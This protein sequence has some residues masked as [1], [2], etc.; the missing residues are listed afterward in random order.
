MHKL[1]AL[2]TLAVLA[3]VSGCALKTS[4]KLEATNKVGDQT[5]RYWY[6]TLTL[7][8]TPNNSFI[9]YH[10]QHKDL[11]LGNKVDVLPETLK[12]LW[13]MDGNPLGDQTVNLARVLPGDQDDAD[14]FYEVNSPASFSWTDTVKNH[15]MINKIATFHVR[16]AF[17]F[18]D[19][20][21][22]VKA[23]REAKWGMKD[24]SCKRDDKEF[25]TITPVVKLPYGRDI[26]IAKSV[27]YFD[28][29]LRPKQ[30]DFLVWERRTKLFPAR[31]A[32]VNKVLEVFRRDTKERDFH[33]YQFTQVMDKDANLLSS[34]P[35]LVKQVDRLAKESNHPL[36][37]FIFYVCYDGVDGCQR[38]ALASALTSKQAS[39]DNGSEY[40]AIPVL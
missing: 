8:D 39:D 21:A 17:K 18:L 23:E 14:F 30:G 1:D 2:R 31:D 20:P 19:C 9:N 32:F 25:A 5:V 22:D 40:G 13:F 10:K 4:S 15:E 28:M 6:E 38:P 16:Y 29:Y 37:D 11:L 34:F 3:L 27:A 26:W 12:G 35:R 33:R 36:K 7:D 24:G